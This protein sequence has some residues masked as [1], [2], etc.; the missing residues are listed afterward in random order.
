MGVTKN[1]KNKK[2]VGSRE[3]SDPANV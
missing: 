1:Y 3:W 2:G